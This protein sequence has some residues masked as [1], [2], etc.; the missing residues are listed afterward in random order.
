MNQTINSTDLLIDESRGFSSV[1]NFALLPIKTLIVLTAVSINMLLIITIGFLMKKKSYSY[2]LFLSTS[3]SDFFLGLFSIPCMIVFT[4]YA[5]WPA[6]IHLCKFWIINDYSCCCIT[7]MNLLLI[8]VHRYRQLTSP[9][10]TSE[11]M[12]KFR[13]IS[14]IL[15]WILAYSFWTTSVVFIVNTNY[16]EENCYF[17]YTFIYVL[18]SSL[19]AYIIPIMSVFLLNILTL[20]ALRK[21][22]NK[23]PKRLNILRMKRLNRA[24]P[25][26]N[27][28]KSFMAS[29]TNINLSNNSADFRVDESQQAQR[30]LAI[31]SSRK[32]SK[33]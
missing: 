8:T 26:Q 5:R 14:I 15:V 4:T 7:F 6:G 23:L 10:K 27:S 11:K 16:I 18:V 12:S 19:V 2:Y 22:M 30:Q 9:T 31:I 33:S 28:A 24:F 1:L 3:F 32:A 25:T 21:Q 17:T 29:N 13:A 20:I